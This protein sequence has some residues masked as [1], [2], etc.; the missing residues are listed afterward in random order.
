MNPDKQTADFYL[1]R[2]I[3]GNYQGLPIEFCLSEFLRWDKPKIK[4][5]LKEYKKSQKARQK[6]LTSQ[7]FERASIASCNTGCGTTCEG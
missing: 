3:V 4:T 1:F 7:L 6:E 2:E 5:F